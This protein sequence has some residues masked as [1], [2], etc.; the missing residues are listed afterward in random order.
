MN[1]TVVPCRHGH[2]VNVALLIA[3]VTLGVIFL[4][5]GSQKLFG[6]FDGPG[7]DKVVEMM[8]TAGYFVAAGEFLGGIALIIGFLSRLASIGIIIIMI[9]ALAIVHGKNGL[10][11][12]NNGC[13]Y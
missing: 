8:G 6:A 3:R 4:A 9:G 7:L 1:S 2:A 12:S 11:L 13:E 10:F 5:H